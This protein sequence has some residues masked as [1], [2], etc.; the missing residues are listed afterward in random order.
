MLQKIKEILGLS[1]HNDDLSEITIHRDDKEP[2]VFR[3]MLLSDQDASGDGYTLE[4][5]LY[6][7]KNN[8]IILETKYVDAEYGI[9]HALEFAN[10]ADAAKHITKIKESMARDKKSLLAL[11]N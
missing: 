4:M 6:A 10:P 9:H 5:R 7:M 1:R 3:G 11:M 2:I 8:K